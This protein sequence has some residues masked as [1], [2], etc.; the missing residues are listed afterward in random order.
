MDVNL[1]G[2]KLSIDACNTHI[3]YTCAITCTHVRQTDRLTG[4]Y[5]RHTIGPYVHI[6]CMHACTHMHIHTLQYIHT[7][8]HTHTRTRTRT[9]THTHTHTHTYIHTH[10]HTCIKYRYTIQSLVIHTYSTAFY[11]YILVSWKLL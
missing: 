9:R 7:Y 2:W 11:I 5:T 8:I 1:L 3:I 4:T 10:I 6:Q